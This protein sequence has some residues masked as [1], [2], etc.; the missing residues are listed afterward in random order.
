M[1]KLLY[2]EASPRGERSRSSTVAKAFIEAYRKAHPGDTV[3]KVNVFDAKLA[4]LDLPTLG[5]KYAVLHGKEPTT[6]ELKRWKPVQ[7]VMDQFKAADKYVIS[8]PMWNFSIPYRLK[9]YIDLLVNPGQTFSYSPKEGYKGLVTGKPIMLVCA[10]G[11][12]YPEGTAGAALDMQTAYLKLVLGFI[13]FTD[14]RW[15]LVEPTLAGPDVADGKTRAAV[16][17]AKQQAKT[18]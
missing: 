12:E 13:G 1:G 11:G 18:F 10:R 4:T 6:A 2:I 14:I 17:R 16:E 3:E 15:I 8:T 5:A 9:H 7:A